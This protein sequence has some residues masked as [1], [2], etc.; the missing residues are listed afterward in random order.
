[1]ISLFLILVPHSLYFSSYLITEP[2]RFEHFKVF[3]FPKEFLL[4]VGCR[5]DMQS[6][7]PKKRR[8]AQ[9]Y[10]SATRQCILLLPR[11]KR[12]PAAACQK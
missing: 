5:S 4:E 11:H 10:S 2:K 6:K 12:V 1:M 8:V 3:T 7:G 9:E